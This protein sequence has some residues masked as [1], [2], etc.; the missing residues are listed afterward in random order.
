MELVVFTVFDSKAEAY[1]QPFFATNVKVALRM[2]ERACND[3]GS[4][5]CRHAEDYTLF[6]I[7]TFDQVQG[8]MNPET[9]IS[10]ARAIELRGTDDE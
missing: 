10:V 4:D 6:R 9:A 5:F 1:M 8:M 2:W 7:G 3:E